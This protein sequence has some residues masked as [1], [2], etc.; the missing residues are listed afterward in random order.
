MRSFIEKLLQV[1]IPEENHLRKLLALEPVALR[2]ILPESNIYGQDLSAL[3][4]YQNKLVRMLVKAVKFRN[5]PRARKVVAELLC[6]DLLEI[7]SDANLFSGAI[8]ILVPMP[9]SKKER[10][11][12][13]YNQCEELVKEMTKIFGS[14]VRTELDLLQKVRDTERQVH[15]SREARTKNLDRSM[16]VVD[17][18]Q[19]LKDKSVVVLDDLYTT[20]STFAEARRALLLGGAKSVYGLFIAH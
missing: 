18:H 2:T 9:M 1:L 20:G 12:R 7:T 14:Q 19:I 10:G 5:N 13:G 3:F 17:P 11:E 6:E 4:D 8:P 16:E 15:L